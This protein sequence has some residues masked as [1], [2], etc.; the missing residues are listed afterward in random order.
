MKIIARMDMSLKFDSYL[1]RSAASHQLP[2]SLTRPCFAAVP[3]AAAETPATWLAPVCTDL[4]APHPICTSAD[5]RR[6]RTSG[7]WR[8]LCSLPGTQT[9]LR[10]TGCAM[11]LGVNAIAAPAAAAHAGLNLGG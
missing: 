11:G 8:V 4:D 9:I 10:T 3:A 5:N 1:T 7:E 6:T 2:I